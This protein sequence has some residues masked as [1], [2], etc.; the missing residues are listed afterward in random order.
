[1]DAGENTKAGESPR[2]TEILDRTLELVRT[3][4]L[5]GLTTK[6]IAER[7]GFSEA[8]LYRHFPT[9]QTLVLG[10]M[11]RLEEMLVQPARQIAA[12]G[13][14][15]VVQRLERIVLHHVRLIREQNSLP[16]LLLAE[17]SA[18][19]DPELLGRM[20]SIFHG[21]LSV[22]EG[23]IREGQT[24]RE[25]ASAVEPDCLALA[26]LGAPAAM[27][28]R[29]RLLPDARAEDRFE[30]QLVPFLLEALTTARGREV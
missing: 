14:L 30:D 7:V 10:L 1:M 16:I 27:A 19:D 17:A 23:L 28:I 20:R 26:L 5:G 15:P 6:K 29:H 21:Y 13:D 25:V 2:Q 11:D 12:E 9:K 4:G 8:A 24:A 22:L 18:S 3:G